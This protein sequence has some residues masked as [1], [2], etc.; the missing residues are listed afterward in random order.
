MLPTTSSSSSSS[1]STGLSV[2]DSAQRAQLQVAM[3]VSK[4]GLLTVLLSQLHHLL[5]LWTMD[6]QQ[7]LQGNMGFR[8]S[9]DTMYCMYVP[10]VV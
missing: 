4:S 6:W 9:A 3:A 8:V 1:N 7:H 2:A 10:L 5:D